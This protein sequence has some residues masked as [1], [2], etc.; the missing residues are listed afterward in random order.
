MD[1]LWSWRPEGIIADA[2][3]KSVAFS[4]GRKRTSLLLQR[5][6]WLNESCRD[7]TKERHV[8]LPRAPDLYASGI[9]RTHCSLNATDRN[10]SACRIGRSAS[11]AATQRPVERHVS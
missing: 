10:R 7:H 5:P 8:P 11:P 1:V 4:L 9:L 2:A 6:N 3:I